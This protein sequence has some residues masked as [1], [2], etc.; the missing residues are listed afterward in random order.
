MIDVR[1]NLSSSLPTAD[2]GQTGSGWPPELM[3]EEELIVFLRVPEVSKAK[4]WR[5]VISNLKRMYD[6]PRIHI[7]GRPLYPLEAVRE[8]IRRHTTAGGKMMIYG[9]PGPRRMSGGPTR[10]VNQHRER[11]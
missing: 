5:K 9:G 8:W 6:L 2:R 7:C 11:R 4:D 3:T 1:D 10:V